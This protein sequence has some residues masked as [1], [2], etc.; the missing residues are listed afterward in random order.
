M[1]RQNLA[2]RSWLKIQIQTPTL[3][4]KTVRTANATLESTVQ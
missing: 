2:R 4:R 3:G 1:R